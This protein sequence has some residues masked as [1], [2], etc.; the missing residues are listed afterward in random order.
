[1][2]NLAGV[3]LHPNCSSQFMRTTNSH[4][5]AL[6]VPTVPL[7]IDPHWETENRAVW[8]EE[9]HANEVHEFVYEVSWV[10]ELLVW[11][12]FLRTHRILS[13]P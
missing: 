2:R 8:N 12:W 3:G 1:M 5:T 13:S 10:P 6:K 4:A 11:R 9:N 7:G